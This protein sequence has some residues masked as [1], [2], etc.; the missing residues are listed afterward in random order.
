MIRLASDCP[1]PIHIVWP[2]RWEFDKDPNTF[3][4]V[5]STMFSW[6]QRMN[7]YRGIEEGWNFFQIITDR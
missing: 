1:R 6:K 3:I 5:L 2:H 4:N 7:D